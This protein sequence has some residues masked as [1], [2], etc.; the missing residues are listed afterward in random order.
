M[1]PAR[2]LTASRL[3][4]QRRVAPRLVAP[5]LVAPRL[6]APRLVLASASPRRAKLLRGL[7]IP[8]A[9]RPVDVDETPLSGEGPSEYV[10]RVSE[11]KAE[12]GRQTA[13][14]EELV[15]AADTIVVLE[16]KLLGKPADR[17]D[18][19]RMILELAGRD[20]T[21]LSGVALHDVANRRQVGDVAESRVFLRPVS[22]EE[23]SWYAAT[24]EPGDKAGGYALQ[25]LGALFVDR[26][27]GNPSNVIGLPLPLVYE[28]FGRLGYDLK[29]M[30]TPPGKRSSESESSSVAESHVP[31][32]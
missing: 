19:R 6:V 22:E 14:D 9:H 21:V 30:V 28:L 12:A 10:R 24:G 23:A 11:L 2:R 32:D 27:E 3:T 26:I 1:S 18:A 7:G 20:H 15:L 16:G 25:G 17:D 31:R 29:K 4:A 13:S 8:F 5:R